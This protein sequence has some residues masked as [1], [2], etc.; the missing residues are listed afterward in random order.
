MY[1]LLTFG[2]LNFATDLAFSP[3][4]SMCPVTYLIIL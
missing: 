4:Y 2:N 3:Q 1:E